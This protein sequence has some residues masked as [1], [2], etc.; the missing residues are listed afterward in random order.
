MKLISSFA[1]VMVTL[2]L[3]AQAP[4]PVPVR[5][6]P[7]HHLAFENSLLRVFR[8]EVAPHDSTLLHQH[9]LDYIFVSLGA[10]DVINAPQG[11]PE[12]HLQL[13]D[14]E[15]RYAPATVIHVARNLSDKPFRNLT[16]EFLQ[17]QGAAHNLC[18][19]IVP[20]DLGPCDRQSG[21]AFQIEPVFETD[22]LRVEIVRLTP[23][24]EKTTLD[25]SGDSLIAALDEAEILVQAPNEAGPGKTLRTGDFLWIPARSPRVFSNL[26][27]ASSRLPSSFLRITFKDS[28]SA[29]AFDCH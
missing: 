10:S 13:A 26:R 4:Q 20:G 12:I 23:S 5:N 2:A 19:Q 1:F 14:G 21:P 3:P 16:I 25:S 7:R 8:V 9:A 28:A 17:P 24:A 27:A 18:R 29:T 11:K 6:E 22:K 15:V